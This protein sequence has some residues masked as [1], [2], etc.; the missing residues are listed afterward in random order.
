MTWKHVMCLGFMG[1]CCLYRPRAEVGCG[2]IYLMETRNEPTA[3]P[4]NASEHDTEPLPCTPN[5]QYIVM[6]SFSFLLIS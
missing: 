6:Q 5:Y 1:Y 3:T 2:D 4:E